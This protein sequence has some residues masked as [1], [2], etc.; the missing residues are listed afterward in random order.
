MSWSY[1][2]TDN[3]WSKRVLDWRSRLVKRSVGRSLAKWQ[4]HLRK[5]SVVAECE[6]PQTGFCSMPWE[7]IRPAVDCSGLMKMMNYLQLIIICNTHTSVVFLLI[8]F[9]CQINDSLKN[10][11]IF[12]PLNK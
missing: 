12:S 10:K 9:N 7:R 6:K 8:L 11:F 3:T 2:R 4:E 5:R 1:R